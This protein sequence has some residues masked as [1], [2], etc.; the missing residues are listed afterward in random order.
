MYKY[1]GG[2]P[3]V[4][5]VLSVLLLIFQLQAESAK[6]DSVFGQGPRLFPDGNKKLYIEYTD[7]AF[8]GD[9]AFIRFTLRS[10]TLENARAELRSPSVDKV[11]INAKLYE[12]SSGQTAASEEKRYIALIPLSSWYEPGTFTITLSYKLRG[13]KETVLSL[14]LLIQPKEFVSETIQLDGRNTAIKTDT[15]TVRKQQ[16]E[17]LNTILE[18]IDYDAVYQRGTFSLPVT[19]KR[20]TAF[21]ADRRV[22]AY[23][24]GKSST[25]LHY[26]IDFGVP[27][28]TPVFS[29]GRGRVVLAEKRVSTGYSAVIEHLPG[30]YSL[31]YHL[32]EFNVEEGQIVGR[33]Q[34]IGLSGATGLATG[35]HLH[36][37]VRLLGRAVNPDFF[38][39]AFPIDK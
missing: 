33:G 37:E 25:G 23:S 17:R 11:L 8:P 36:W 15:S 34:K 39:E 38:T 27:T 21:F 16:I 20:R 1:I 7:K 3:T 32:S 31:Y 5:A 28:G 2:K 35:P 22:Y 9:A 6:T 18:T 19:Q 29:C 14:P 13:K 10:S 4:C 30:L 24:D 26:G 12:V